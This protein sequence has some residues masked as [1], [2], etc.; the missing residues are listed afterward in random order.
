MGLGKGQ[1]SVPLRFFLISFMFLKSCSDS[2]YSWGRIQ[3]MLIL[4]VEQQK[5]VLGGFF[6]CLLTFT[7]SSCSIPKRAAMT[8]HI[9]PVH[10]I[11]LEINLCF[12]SEQNFFPIKVDEYQGQHMQGPNQTPSQ[13][14]TTWSHLGD[15]YS[16][17]FSFG[18]WFSC[19]P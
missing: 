15:W 10:W 16:C 8:L 13:D 2:W 12:V 11:N 6:C 9:S 18:D 4:L 5:V 17:N 19:S 14:Q 1:N 7:N 3:M